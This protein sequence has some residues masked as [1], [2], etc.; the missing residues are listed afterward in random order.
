MRKRLFLAALAALLA[1]PSAANSLY[2]NAW[3]RLYDAGSIADDTAAAFTVDASGNVYT[4]SYSNVSSMRWWYV[5][6]F[7]QYGNLIWTQSTFFTN[8]ST[9]RSIAVNANGMIYVCGD[10]LDNLPS[11]YNA[12]TYALNKNGFVTWISSWDSP[13]NYV[14]GAFGVV[15]DAQGD[16]QTLI[17]SSDLSGVE[18]ILTNLNSEYSGGLVQSIP[19]MTMQLASNVVGPEP[20]FAVTGTNKTGAA[21]AKLDISGAY[22]YGEQATRTVVNGVTTNHKYN[23]CFDPQNNLYVC[24]IKTIQSSSSSSSSYYFRAFDPNGNL[25]WTSAPFTNTSGS[26]AASSTGVLYFEEAIGSNF[27]LHGLSQG[28]VNWTAPLTTPGALYADGTT[29][30]FLVAT[31]HSG[32]S[33]S[34][35]AKKYD[36]NG[37]AMW[38]TTYAPPGGGNAQAHQ[39]IARNGVLYVFGTAANGVNG[40]DLYLAKYIEGTG[41]YSMALT[42]GTATGHISVPGS[43]TL[44]G[45]APADIKVNLQSSDPAAVGVPSSTTVLKGSN[46]AKFTCVTT[47][48]DSAQFVRITSTYNGASRS[49]TIQLKPFLLATLDLSTATVSSGTSL[50][51]TATLAGIAGTSGR[52]IALSS[53]HPLVA[54]VPASVYI[55]PNTKS[56]VFTVT[57]KPVGTATNVTITASQGGVIKTASVNVTP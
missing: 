10:T 8:G 50:T 20:A 47:A 25:L 18:H 53:D 56:R 37:N 29:G 48:V 1:V 4:L 43:V 14:D 12:T 19:S 15:C 27:L 41:L 3:S 30:L 16:V 55:L 34:I 52:S 32:T 9:P 26:L 22:Q 35:V 33:T 11:N 39:S 36:T 40:N 24:Q 38:A 23:L 6:K 49:A 45:N 17:E 7:D 13:S 51:G 28:V 44:N 31:D 5:H 54:T 42:S 57:T 46:I 21:F 2:T